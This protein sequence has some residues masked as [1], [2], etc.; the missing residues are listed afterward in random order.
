MIK[1]LKQLLKACKDYGE[2]TVIDAMEEAYSN[3]SQG[4]GLLDST[5][6]YLKSKKEK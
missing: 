3:G 4:T 6:E 2:Q 1:T 5:L